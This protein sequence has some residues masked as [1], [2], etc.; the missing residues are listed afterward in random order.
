MLIKVLESIKSF[1][2][3]LNRLEEAGVSLDIF[4]D[5]IMTLE[6]VACHLVGGE[7]YKLI[8]VLYEMLSCNESPEQ[9]ADVMLQ[10]K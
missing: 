8:N 4:S 1:Q 7:K 10:A 2:D 6:L 3:K 9:I 5:E